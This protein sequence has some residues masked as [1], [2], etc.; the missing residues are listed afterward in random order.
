MWKTSIVEKINW[1]S[2]QKDGKTK[3][4]IVFGIIYVGSKNMAQYKKYEHCSIYLKSSQ[5]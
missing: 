1:I 5:C 3:P 2:S 4:G